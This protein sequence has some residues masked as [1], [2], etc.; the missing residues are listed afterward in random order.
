MHP[1]STCNSLCV[2]VFFHPCATNLP[3]K[4]VL[5]LLEGVTKGLMCSQKREGPDLTAIKHNRGDHCL[6][7]HD[8]QANLYDI[9]LL[10]L[11]QD[12]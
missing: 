9:S 10:C 2:T 8:F 12:A 3:K 1:N 7:Q 11:A 4:H 6:K 5:E